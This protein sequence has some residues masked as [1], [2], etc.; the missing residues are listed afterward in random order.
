[1]ADEENSQRHEEEE[2][3]LGQLIYKQ[4]VAPAN[5]TKSKNKL[6][7]MMTTGSE[8]VNNVTEEVTTYRE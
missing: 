3:P 1:M 8:V 4:R 5:I 2:Q 7:G 6:I